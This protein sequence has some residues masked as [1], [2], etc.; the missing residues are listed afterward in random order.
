MWTSRLTADLAAG[1]ADLTMPRRRLQ[2]PLPGMC[3]P[4]TASRSVGLA[5]TDEG[6]EL[7]ATLGQISTKTVTPSWSPLL[8]FQPAGAAVSKA[9]TPLREQLHKLTCTSIARKSTIAA[10]LASHTALPSACPSC[11]AAGDGEIG[12]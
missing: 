12:W 7:V 10:I 8:R 4:H 5:G 3:H 2:L 6:R 9:P 1:H 11:G